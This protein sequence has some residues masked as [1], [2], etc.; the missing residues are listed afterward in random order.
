MIANS[1]LVMAVRLIDTYGNSM[2]GQYVTFSLG[3]TN[4]TAYLSN[5]SGITDGNGQVGTTVFVGSGAGYIQ[6][7]ANT[8]VV[9]CSSSFQIY[10]PPL[11]PPPPPYNP[12]KPNPC[13]YAP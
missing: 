6:V 4:G 8:G 10:T 9:A 5:S 13:D 2:P 11:P 1:S 7:Q 12:P 3:A